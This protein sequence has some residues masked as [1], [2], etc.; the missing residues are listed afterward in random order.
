MATDWP[1]HQ[2]KFD[3]IVIIL[4]LIDRRIW[5]RKK[6]NERKLITLFFTVS[7]DSGHIMEQ[8]T[9]HIT[10]GRRTTYQQPDIR[11]L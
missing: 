10:R 5:F 2:L 1:H 11:V 8:D 7:L 6:F 4:C 3:Q 9:G